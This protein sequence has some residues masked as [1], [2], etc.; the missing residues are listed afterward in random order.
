MAAPISPLT[1][2]APEVGYGIA[3]LLVGLGL[4]VLPKVLVRQ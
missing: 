2:I 1:A 3:A 4:S